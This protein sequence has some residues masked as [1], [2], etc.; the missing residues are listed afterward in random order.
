M[1]NAFYRIKKYSSQQKLLN[2]EVQVCDH[3]LLALCGLRSSRRGNRHG[4]A[5]KSACFFQR[6]NVKAIRHL[7]KA[8]MHP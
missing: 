2:V 6:R 7:R 1:L 8:I 5:R 3:M 4:D